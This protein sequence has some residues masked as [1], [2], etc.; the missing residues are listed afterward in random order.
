MNITGS[1]TIQ[2]LLAALAI[3]VAT[4]AIAGVASGEE[5]VTLTDQLAIQ[6]VEGGV[7]LL[8]NSMFKTGVDVETMQANIPER[9]VRFNYYDGHYTGLWYLIAEGALAP[10]EARPEIVVWGFRPRYAAL[11]A[12]R[13]NRPNSTELFEFEDLAYDRL[14]GES[15][16]T[17]LIDAQS[18]L[19][20][21]SGIYARRSDV[22]DAIS[23]T[24][25]RVGLETLDAVGQNVD[26]LWDRLID[27]ETTIADEIVRAA[28]GG[29]VQLTEEQ[30]VDG[31]GD[32]IIGPT[33]DFADGF[34]PLTVKSF[35][36]SG[37]AQLVVIWRPAD[38]AQG[39]PI[40]EEDLFV[41]EAIE[42]F[43]ENG[44]AYVDF[45]HD[46]R[47]D[48][49]VFAKGDH[50]NADGR[51]AVTAILTDRIRQLLSAIDS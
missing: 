38:V 43:E 3:V 28:T 2:I 18:F 35:R 26:G 12:F 10:S 45:Y 11:P 46:D 48:L 19:Q 32:F 25:E 31:V 51:S 40:P 6:P 24:T 42:Y 8:G 9:D 16:A 17:P 5:T 7:Y 4:D 39:A 13:Q 47:I 30:V 49:A 41:A 34:I 36:D 23:R 14:T 50:Y 15:V 29:E 44:I 20:D 1:K 37:L 22:Q 27:G 33:L 21:W